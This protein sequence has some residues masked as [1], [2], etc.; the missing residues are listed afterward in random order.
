MAEILGHSFCPILVLPSSCRANQK[1]AVWTLNAE[2]GGIEVN[3]NMGKRKSV[4]LVGAAPIVKFC[5]H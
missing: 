3:F 5:T 1:R 2:T 4:R